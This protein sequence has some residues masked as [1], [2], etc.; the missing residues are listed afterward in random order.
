M[1]KFC[2]GTKNLYY[3]RTNACIQEVYIEEDSTLSI[4]CPLIDSEDEYSVNLKINY[5]PMCGKK[6]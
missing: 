3:S 5:C 4:S 6:F 1:C 2:K